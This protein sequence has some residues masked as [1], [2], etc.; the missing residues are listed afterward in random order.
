MHFSSC[1]GKAVVSS[2]V[3]E[4]CLRASRHS[5]NK[6]KY[7]KLSFSCSLATYT[8]RVENM[9]STFLGLGGVNQ[10]CSQVGS[11]SPQ[12]L[13]LFFISRSDLMVLSIRPT[14]G[15]YQ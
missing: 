9:F 7:T 15:N 1:M 5:E 10:I 13:K 11:K 2:Q 3:L 12:R 4:R 6:N 8:K 14:K